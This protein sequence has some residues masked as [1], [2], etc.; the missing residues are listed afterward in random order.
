[1]GVGMDW[2]GL[3]TFSQSAA[4]AI[5]EILAGLTPKP[6]PSRC[7]DQVILSILSQ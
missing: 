4:G 5:I 1:M 3:L 7:G 2:E 6:D